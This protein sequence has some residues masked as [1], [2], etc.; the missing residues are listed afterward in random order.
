VNQ[1]GADRLA[2][3]EAVAPTSYAAITDPETYS[4]DL[5]EQAAGEDYLARVAD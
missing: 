1:Y 4:T 5:G 2:A 3:P